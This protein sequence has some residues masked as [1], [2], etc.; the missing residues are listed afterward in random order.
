MLSQAPTFI[1]TFAAISLLGAFLKFPIY[2]HGQT[3]Q[4]PT[5]TLSENIKGAG[6]FDAFD[7]QNIP[8]PTGGR[9]Y[10]ASAQITFLQVANLKGLQKLR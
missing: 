1:S 7:F 4:S 9:V 8:D 6:F 10:V 5:Y 2:A 3:C